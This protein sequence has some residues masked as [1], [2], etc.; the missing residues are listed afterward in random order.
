[1]R[2]KRYTALNIVFSNIDCIFCY[3]M[4]D[5]IQEQRKSECVFSDDFVQRTGSKCL[6]SNR[7]GSYELLNFAELACEGD[8]DCI[9]I[10]DEHC[11]RKG[12][13]QLC[14]NGYLAQ[15][16][17]TSSCLYQKRQYGSK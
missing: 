6:E 14:I 3:V 9:G 15:D 10:Y 1:M 7:H 12:P 17:Y 2:G 4:I 5:N 11:D 16:S 13:F 8:A